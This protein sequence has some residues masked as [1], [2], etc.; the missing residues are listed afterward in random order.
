MREL[1]DFWH[2]QCIKSKRNIMV[3]EDMTLANNKDNTNH[4][5]RFSPVNLEGWLA[6]NQPRLHPTKRKVL[7]AS[8]D[9]CS[10]GQW[11]SS[12]EIREALGM[13]QQ[14]LNRHLRGLQSQNLLEISPMGAGL[15]L[16]VRPTSAGL[17]ALSQRGPGRFSASP[18][19]AQKAD[20]PIEKKAQLAGA[21]QRL[22]QALSPYLK[23]L[24]EDGFVSLIRKLRGRVGSGPLRLPKPPHPH[25]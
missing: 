10:H 3:H 24:D 13:S 1:P 12:S 6:A 19:E 25:P 18:Q 15:P 16:N 5:H 17:R 11:I 4:A 9:L 8:A 7:Q 2:V 20:E 22:Y 14:L 23:D 21:G